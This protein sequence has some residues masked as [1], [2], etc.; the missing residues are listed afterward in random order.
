M[1]FLAFNIAVVTALFILFNTDKNDLKSA[2]KQFNAISQKVKIMAPELLNK[3]E[4]KE[5]EKKGKL[6]PKKVIKK[7]LQ[8]KQMIPQVEASLK[9]IFSKQTKL[10]KQNIRPNL[11]KVIPQRKTLQKNKIKRE[12]SQNFIKNKLQTKPELYQE[13][14]IKKEEK[15]VKISNNPSKT[16]S[17]KLPVSPTKVENPLNAAAKK[18]GAKIE[19]LVVGHSTNLSEP[20]IKKGDKLMSVI[21]RRRELLRLAEEMAFIHADNLVR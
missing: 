21:E 6:I 12:K 3:E 10:D 19:S 15:K 7:Q 13:K 9:P 16:S 20:I 4:G 11:S 18:R 14:Q 1:K 17:K 8:Q 5:L 2:G